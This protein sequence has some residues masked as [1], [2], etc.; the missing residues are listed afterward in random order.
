VDELDVLQ[1]MKFLPR[2]F[3]VAIS[4][5]IVALLI[6]PCIARY[7][8]SLNAFAKGTPVVGVGLVAALAVGSV[9]FVFSLF[10]RAP[11]FHQ[12]LIL[13]FFSPIL[14]VPLFYQITDWLSDY[15][16]H[17][18]GFSFR[19]SPLWKGLMVTLVLCWIFIPFGLLTGV[20]SAFASKLADKLMQNKPAHPTAGNVLL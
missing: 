17:S 6:A 1:K 10:L 14:S 16:I 8:Y 13:G 15:E 12:W 7:G 4:A 9:W 18:Y 19:E 11:K 20:V 3:A 2:H 5:A